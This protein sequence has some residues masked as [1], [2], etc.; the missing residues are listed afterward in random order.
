MGS[1]ALGLVTVAFAMARAAEEPL[2]KKRKG[3]VFKP[4]QKP[5][6][7]VST[8]LVCELTYGPAPPLPAPPEVRAMF[9]TEELIVGIDVETHA[10]GT[11]AA[12]GRMAGWQLWLTDKARL[13]QHRAAEAH[14]AR[15]GH[16]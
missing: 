15:V 8:P 2:P 6:R 12:D 16:R 13:G 7:R 14:S 4:I 3:F 1:N 10:L 5:E 9:H 11:T